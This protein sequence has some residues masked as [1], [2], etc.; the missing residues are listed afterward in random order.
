M[1]QRIPIEVKGDKVVTLQMH[2]LVGSHMVGII[3]STEVWN[4][5]TNYQTRIT[6][7]LKS[8]DKQPAKVF[9]FEL[10]GRYTTLCDQLANCHYFFAVS[11]IGNAIVEISFPKMPIDAPA[12]IIV[13]K[14]P[15]ETESPY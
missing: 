13:C 15:E 3:C 11:A 9:G 1:H 14:T 8:S 7:R 4:E 5:L 12:E 10:G 2:G 6:V